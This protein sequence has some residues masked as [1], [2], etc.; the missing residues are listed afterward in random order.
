MNKIGYPQ[1]CLNKPFWK[2]S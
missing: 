2:R 1:N